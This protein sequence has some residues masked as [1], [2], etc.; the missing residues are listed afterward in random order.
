MGSALLVLAMPRCMDASRNATLSVV[1]SLI[2]LKGGLGYN[3]LM[4][5]VDQLLESLRL[6]ALTAW[7]TPVSNPSCNSYAPWGSVQ[8]CIHPMHMGAL[9]LSSS[10]WCNSN[11][12][13]LFNDASVGWPHCIICPSWPYCLVFVE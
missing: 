5:H 13:W 10:S 2:D 4:G 3:V 8:T 9:R 7:S 1:E 12:L 11:M 6:I